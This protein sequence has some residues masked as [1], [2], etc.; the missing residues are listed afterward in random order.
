MKQWERFNYSL[1]TWFERV[2]IIGVFGMILTTLTDVVGAKVFHAPLGPGT[3]LVYIFQII[4]I[5]GTLAIA[6]LDGRHIRIE[7]VDK[8]PKHSRAFIATLVAILGLGLFIVLC[9]KSIEHGQV[10]L[11]SHEVSSTSKIVLYPFVFWL[12]V[13]CIPMISILLREFIT[14]LAELFSK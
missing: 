13:C 3:E 7:F 4:A 5:A 10:L 6:K 14:S 1:S 8:L 9:W 2:A 11:A 12:A